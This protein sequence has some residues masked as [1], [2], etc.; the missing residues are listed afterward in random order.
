MKIF[1]DFGRI[2]FVDENNVF[3][4]FDFTSDCCEYFGYVFVEV[5][6][7][8]VD[9]GNTKGS[10]ELSELE[11]KD[12]NF[13]I[14]FNKNLAVNWGGDATSFRLVNNLNKEIYLIL[15]NHH[16]G[17]YSHGFEMKDNETLIFD[18]YL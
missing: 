12:F 9:G 4:G 7:E 14:T 6:P 13:D 8:M 2:N 1:E 5:L 15:F 16:D 17:Y 10:I 3:V 11:L 18:G